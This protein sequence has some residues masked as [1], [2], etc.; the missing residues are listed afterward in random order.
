[1]I[2]PINHPALTVFLPVQLS[3]HVDDCSLAPAVVRGRP[4]LTPPHPSR[5]PGPYRVTEPARK[6][7]ARRNPEPQLTRPA[8]PCAPLPRPTTVDF[9]S[10]SAVGYHSTSTVRRPSAIIIVSDRRLSPPIITV[11]K[12][13]TR[14]PSPITIVQRPSCTTHRPSP[15][16]DDALPHATSA[17]TIKRRRRKK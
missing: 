5:R 12:P 15:G 8:P 11:T 4:R 2:A 10:S 16:N 6:S 14:H 7:N 17:K 3:S 9:P 13:F 1:M